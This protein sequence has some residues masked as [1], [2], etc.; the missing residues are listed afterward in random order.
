VGELAV[1]PSGALEAALG[2]AHGS[3]LAQ[4]AQGIDERPVEPNRE[5]KSVSH[6]ET[7][8]YDLHDRDELKRA[9]VRMAD[10]VGARMRR[11][12]VLGRTVTL[13]VRFGDYVTR[14]PSPPMSS[15]RGSTWTGA[16]ACWAW[17][18]RISAPR[19]REIP[20]ARSRC[21][22]AW[23]TRKVGSVKAP[24]PGSMA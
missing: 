12:G 24:P 9:L 3:Q 21:G 1:V 6:E 13:K 14:T 22:W 4:L 2:R 10:A 15:W 11:A 16:S 23:T 17:A 20:P 5:L 7:Y 8:P 19:S 18:C